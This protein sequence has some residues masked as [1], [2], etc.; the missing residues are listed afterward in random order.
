M[1]T[2]ENMPQ[3]SAFARTQ[4]TSVFT[5]HHSGGNAT[6]TGIFS[7]F[8]GLPGPYWFPALSSGTPSALITALQKRH[9][10]IGTFTGR[11]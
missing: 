11:P 2:P 8:Y 1:V 10:A 3:L 9:Y 6:R 4:D 7:V 5:N